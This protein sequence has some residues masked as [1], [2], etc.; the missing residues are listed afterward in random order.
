MKMVTYGHD[1]VPD[2]RD[3]LI[4]IHAQANGPQ[5]MED[6]FNQSFPTFVDM[7]G[8]NKD[9]ACVIAY[10]SDDQPV[11]FIYGAPRQPGRDWWSEH[12][13][14]EGDTTTFAVSEL[15]ILPS[16]RGT[17]LSKA[18]HGRLLEDRSEA[19]SVLLVDTLHPKVQA[20][21]ESWGYER[22]GE[23]KPFADSPLYA[24]MLKPLR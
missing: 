10:D 14:R 22:V 23:R 12:V 19:L 1:D 24:V 13:Q 11:G 5:A 9:F 3:T 2:V 21:Y 20:L 8:G 7:W 4:A 18:L 16:Q 17:G 6:P 15:A